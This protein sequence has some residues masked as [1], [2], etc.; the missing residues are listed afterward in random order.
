[1]KATA[2]ATAS[3]ATYNLCRICGHRGILPSFV[4]YEMMFGTRATFHYFQCS[5]C[6]TVQIDRIPENLSP[7]Y[8]SDYYSRKTKMHNRAKE[9]LASCRDAYSLTGNGVIGRAMSTYRPDPVLPL[10]ASCCEQG[11]KESRIVDIGCGDAAVTLRQLDKLGFGKLVGVD[12][13][14]SHEKIVVSPNLYLRRAP[15][16][17]ADPAAELILLNHSFEHVPDPRGLLISLRPL[18][19]PTGRV[20]IRVPI[21]G[22]AW[23]HYGTNWVQLDPPRHLHLLSVVGMKRLATAAG[24]QVERCIYDSTSFQFWGSESLAA[25]RCLASVSKP[26]FL[27]ELRLRQRARD[28]NTRGEGDSAAFILKTD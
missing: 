17:T 1:M 2:T 21:L 8:P 7:Y 11:G 16:S 22:Y 12:P 15:L 24:L 9:W 27:A 14:L 20:L 18:L 6:D 28:L 25:G 10:I 13:F 23:R 5:E 26:G 19:A 3:D 4:C